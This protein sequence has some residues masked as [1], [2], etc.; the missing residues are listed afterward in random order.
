MNKPLKR[1]PNRLSEYDY[2]QNVAYFITICTDN[3][4]SF[5]SRIVGAYRYFKYIWIFEDEFFTTDS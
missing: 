3:R 1:K 5:L 4:K 2:S